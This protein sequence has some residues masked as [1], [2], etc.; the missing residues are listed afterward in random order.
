LA[1]C[2]YPIIA[3]VSSGPY[4]PAVTEKSN[5]SRAE[6]RHDRLA[7]ELRENLR[8]RKAQ[9]RARKQPASESKREH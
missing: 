8:R 6:Q 7:R 3:A 9:A 1:A 2:E 4:V 5:K